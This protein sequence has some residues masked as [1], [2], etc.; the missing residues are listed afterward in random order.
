MNDYSAAPKILATRPPYAA[1][2]GIS[3]AG[4][5]PEGLKGIGPERVLELDVLTKRVREINSRLSA[6]AADMMAH[7][8]SIFGPIPMQGDGAVTNANPV[9]RLD[10]LSV[11]LHDAD[12]LVTVVFDQL[13]RFRT[14]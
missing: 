5:L 4:Q 8:D 2:H 14:L 11:A 7:A 9:G 3:G 6:L 10:G 13:K 1:P 12:R